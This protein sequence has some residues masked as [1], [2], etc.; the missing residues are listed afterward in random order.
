MNRKQ[1]LILLV[2]VIVVGGAG[3][4]IR[5]RSQSAWQSADKNIGQKL[6]AGLAIND[7]A[8]LVI[9]HDTN[10]L[11][12]ARKDNLWRVKERG[13]YPANF[14]QISEFLIK[15]GDLKVTQSEKVGGSQLP[16]LALAPGQG[17]NLP[18]VVEFKDSSD[19]TLRSLLLGKKH[20]KKSERPSPMGEMGD[21]GWPDGRWV[22]VGD[23]DNV[24]VI[25]EAFVNLE[26]KPDQWLNKDFIHVEKVRSLAVAFQNATNS[27]KLTRETETG[28]WK[29]ADA[30]PAE[31]LDSTKTSSLAS[32]L[33]SPTFSDVAVG[34]KAENLGLDK[35]TTVT[36]ET[37]DR[38]T[39]T[40]K[41]G[42]KTNDT[43]PLTL[44]VTAQLPKERTPGKD[45]KAEDKTKLDKEFK[46]S[47]KKMED[48]LAQEKT[49]EPWTY[50]VS[51]WT[52]DSLLKERSQLLVEKKDET[53]KDD[54]TAGASSSSGDDAA[55]PPAVVAPAN[56]K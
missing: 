25:S 39:Y 24:A 12:L 18:T 11:N 26:P 27:W 35:P 52:L 13:D 50:L 21:E 23:S 33:G 32:A 10:E 51:S 17:T 56:D 31:K 43:V 36:L 48:K 49:Y 9:K 5:Q 4:M 44:S 15:A 8:H 54:K 20:M 45:E 42:Q 14:Q 16:K 6:L 37:F 29:L 55:A 22:K 41:V 7:V 53:K 34:A 40:L 47:Q 28:E 2:L 46:D 1:L 30:T 3:L 19:K 38:F